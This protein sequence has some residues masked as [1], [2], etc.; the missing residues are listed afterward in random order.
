MKPTICVDLDN[1][2]VYCDTLLDLWL[3]ILYFKPKMALKALWIAWSKGI[4]ACKYFLNQ[5]DLLDV[6]QLTYN[7]SLITW[8]KQQKKSHQVWLVTGTSATI[9]HQVADYLGLFD[10]VMSSD[11]HTGLVGQDKK[12]AMLKK[13]KSFIYIGDSRKD[14]QVWPSAYKKGIVYQYENPYP[15]IKFD[16]EFKKPPVGI[17]AWIHLL[18]FQTW[19]QHLL[20]LWPM[21]F[22]PK[23]TLKLLLFMLGMICAHIAGALIH[24]LLYLQQNRRQ[25]IH[26]S[27]IT[28]G[29]YGLTDV[30][31]HS[32]CFKLLALYIGWLVASKAMLYLYI[33]FIL[34][35]IYDSNSFKRLFYFSLFN[36]IVSL[37][38]CT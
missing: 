17:K 28:M 1:T 23:T 22:F 33:G 30:L 15:E 29:I 12:N 6:S 11:Q 38:I 27:I 25:K 37:S 18:G 10:G 9:A 34:H 31:K 19:W 21:I 32:F 3:K 2:L 4:V 24:Q 36:A 35:L 20:I 14:L 26:H 13:F 8:I 5:F 7:A 16:Y